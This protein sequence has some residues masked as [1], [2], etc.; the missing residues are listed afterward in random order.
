MDEDITLLLAD[1][2]KIC[3]LAPDYKVCCNRDCGNCDFPLFI[4]KSEVK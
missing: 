4:K 1:D 3:I 2:Y